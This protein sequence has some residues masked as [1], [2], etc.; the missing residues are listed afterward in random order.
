M[1]FS[2]AVLIVVD[3]LMWIFIKIKCQEKYKKKTEAFDTWLD[4]HQIDDSA[5][6]IFLAAPR[7]VQRMVYE[8]VFVLS[9]N[10]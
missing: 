6:R 5:R 10:W 3:M 8:E 1:H 7:E 4:Q 9:T 2:R